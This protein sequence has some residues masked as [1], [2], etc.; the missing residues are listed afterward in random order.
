MSS[1]K[2]ALQKRSDGR[3]RKTLGAFLITRY[4]KCLGKNIPLQP[5]WL[6]A[7]PCF[8]QGRG[9]SIPTAA[10]GVSKGANSKK[11]FFICQGSSDRTRPKTIVFW[12]APCYEYYQ[13]V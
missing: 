12:G 10:E 9:G 3:G 5:E 13:E 4:E 11:L 6:A 8:G 2:G 1:R 7:A